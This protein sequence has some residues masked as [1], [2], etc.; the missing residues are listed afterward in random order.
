M[1][2]RAIPL[3]LLLFL[4]PT[5]ARCDPPRIDDKAN[6]ALKQMSACLTGAQAFSFDVHAISQQF[7][8]DGHRI[9]FARNQSVLVRRPDHVTANVVGDQENFQFFY[10]GSHCTLFN[11][12][13]N[14]YA[15]ID[16]PP[17]IDATLDMLSAKYGMAIPLADLLFSDPYKVLTEHLETA[18]YI[19]AGYVFKTLCHHVACSQKNVDWQIWIDTGDKPLPC[20][21]TITYKLLPG[22]PSYTAFLSNWNLSPDAADSHFIFTAP[23]DAKQVPWTNP[24]TQPAS[25]ARPIRKT[26]KKNT[27]LTTDEHR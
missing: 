11:L 6:D 2:T 12:A 7:T 1:G 24:T 22:Q 23:T 4:I 10:D 8:V 14:A 20:K 13:H 26:N 25:A 15:T 27:K 16:A 3:T 9:D 19:G 21:I 18:R 17:T 5:I